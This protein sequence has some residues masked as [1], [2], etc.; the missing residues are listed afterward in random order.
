M[1]SQQNTSI[2][3]TKGITIVQLGNLTIKTNLISRNRFNDLR[4]QPVIRPHEV[5][6]I[7]K[8]KLKR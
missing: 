8:L 7:L 2:K 4:K 6:G 5:L 3:R 1:T